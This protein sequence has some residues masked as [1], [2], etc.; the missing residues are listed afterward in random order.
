MNKKLVLVDGYSILENAFYHVP[1]MMNVQ[2]EHTN[3]VYGFLNILL[4]EVG[5]VQPEYL[6]VVF[7]NGDESI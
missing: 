6:M 3:G 7:G 5:R 2:G 4:G 1:D